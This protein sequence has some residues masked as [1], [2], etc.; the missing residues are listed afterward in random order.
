MVT[1]GRKGLSS[2]QVWGSGLGISTDYQVLERAG[3][4]RRGN[5][6]LYVLL[7]LDVAYTLHYLSKP[8]VHES[9]ECC[10]AG[11]PYNQG[12]NFL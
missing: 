5:P 2:G 7:H 9:T 4:G 12:K 11:L 3:C 6:D 1:L 8:R 10:S